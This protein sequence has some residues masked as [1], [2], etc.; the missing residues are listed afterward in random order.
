MASAIMRKYGG[1]DLVQIA[2]NQSGL[3]TL[4][5]EHLSRQTESDRHS[6]RLLFKNE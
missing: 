1:K 6:D 5:I 3:P 2:V 4:I